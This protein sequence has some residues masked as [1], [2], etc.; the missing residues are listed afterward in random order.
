MIVYIMFKEMPLTVTLKAYFDSY[1]YKV[2]Y[3][4]VD[5]MRCNVSHVSPQIP[6]TW[7]C[8]PFSVHVAQLHRGMVFS[9]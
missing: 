6:R 4:I 7:L 9:Y 8:S 5:T 2:A 1:R 3:E